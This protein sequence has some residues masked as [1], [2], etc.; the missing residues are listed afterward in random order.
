MCCW[1]ELVT[2]VELNMDTDDGPGLVK[3]NEEEE[4][5]PLC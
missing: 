2:D 3:A 1:L 5:R 4:E